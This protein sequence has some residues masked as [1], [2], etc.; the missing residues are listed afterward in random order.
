MRYLALTLLFAFSAS[1]ANWTDRKEYD[2]V[3]NIRA[4]SS[5]QTR[6]D[7]LD[8]W[9]SAYPKSEFAPVR[10]ELYLS[11]YQ[12]LGDSPRTF[13]VASE[14]LAAQPDSL[15]GAY[16]FTLLL[17]EEKAASPGKLALG[18]KAAGRFLAGGGAPGGVES[19]AHRTLGWI[20]W[21]RSEYT[22]A[23]EEFQKCLQL[24]PTATE[25]S[26]W[27]G[28]VLGL[29]QQPGKRV[30][31]LWQLA[32]AAAY[33]DS[34]ALSDGMRRQYG[35]VL[36]RLYTSYHG[37][38]GGLDQLRSAAAAA[39]FPP[40]GFDIESAAAAALRKQDEALSSI[41][42]QLAAWVRI[43]QALEAAD[44]DQYFAGTIHNNPLPKLKGTLIQAEPKGKPD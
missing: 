14:L 28:T 4:A 41:N 24:D 8:Q 19:I 13:G 42:P 18:E 23:E 22:P 7:L 30:P 43:R 34:G 9:K 44:G 16:W 6:I 15:V 21:Q 2:L 32:R 11:A 1:A 37:D 3:L 40:A 17:P 25:I 12:E 10:L 5:P 31:A 27:L 20:H 33:R 26:A 38:A 35:E 39:P 29:E 36:E